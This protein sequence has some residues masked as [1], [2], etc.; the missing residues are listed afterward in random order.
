MNTLSRRIECS[1]HVRWHGRERE[2][3]PGE[4]PAPVQSPVQRV[5]R[6]SRLMALAIRFE[7]LL[8]EGSI[9][10]YADLARLG[11]VT[12]ARV[13]QIMALR[14]LA[15]DIQEELLFLPLVE[16][17]RGSIHMWQVLPIA[18]L[19]SWPAQR[20]RWRALRSSS[21]AKR[22]QKASVNGH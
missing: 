19:L 6:V 9:G 8:Q 14:Q 12:P 15:P 3:T 17:G 4:S 16:R 22:D 20:R 2:F 18:G 21:S 7:Q 11:R 10:S 1:F 5:P 13:S